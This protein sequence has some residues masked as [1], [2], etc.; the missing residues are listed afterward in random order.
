MRGYHAEDQP[1]VNLTAQVLS[2]RTDRGCRSR[3]AGGSTSGFSV[4]AGNDRGVRGGAA[5]LRHER[6]GVVSL[7]RP[8]ALPTG[9]TVKAAPAGGLHH[10]LQR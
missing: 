8:T 3:D 5:H 10:R 2:R 6:T 4:L 1:K 9:D 7:P